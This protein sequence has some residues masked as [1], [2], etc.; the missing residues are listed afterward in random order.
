[1]RIR[2]VYQGNLA[3]NKVVNAASGSQTNTYSCDYIENKLPAGITYSL[4]A[5]ASITVTSAYAYNTVAL[6]NTSAANK[7]DENEL[8]D[9]SDNNGWITIK[10]AGYY[11]V[12]GTIMLKSSDTAQTMIGAIRC[13]DANGSSTSSLIEAYIPVGRNASY[14]VGMAPVVRRLRVGDKLAIGV[15]GSSTGSITV[16]GA[17]NGRFTML[18][19]MKL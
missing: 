14:S 5:N 10:K 4:S 11:L 12:G 16:N 8:F 6:D 18:T 15:S 9:V 1:M 19:V 17:S 2:K 7:I 3:D 13:Y